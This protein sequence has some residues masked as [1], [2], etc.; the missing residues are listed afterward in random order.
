MVTARAAS[1]VVRA[2]TFVL[3]ALAA[4]SVV[5]WTLKLGTRSP[6]VAAVPVA[7][8][9]PAP[10]DPM[11]VARL[12]GSSPA[13]QQAAAPVATLASRF[14]LL[15]VAA[16]ASGVGAALISVDGKPAKPYR[17][18]SQLDEG[19]VLQAVQGRRAVLAATAG[20][21]PLVTLEL[22]PLRR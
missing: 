4:A 1:W 21:P 5:Y 7:A 18:G 12:L 13:A 17:V 20:G 16:R 3:W 8:R 22:P 10:I 11:A 6:P 14:S 9:A 2:A 19:I 15:G